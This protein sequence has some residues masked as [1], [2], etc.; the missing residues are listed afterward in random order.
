MA[1]ENSEKKKWGRRLG[2]TIAWGV[3]ITVAYYVVLFRGG[4]LTWFSEYSK[5]LTF[6]LGFLVGGLTITDVVLKK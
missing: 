5:Y 2:C 1:N 3:L 4:D 6:G